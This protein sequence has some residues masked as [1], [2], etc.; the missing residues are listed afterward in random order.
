MITNRLEILLREMECTC[1]PDRICSHCKA[2]SAFT[3]V[4]N[5]IEAALDLA[6]NDCN[7]DCSCDRYDDEPDAG[8]SVNCDHCDHCAISSILRG[9]S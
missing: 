6:E 3:D 8:H 7:C 9:D 5:A 2:L 4:R 1:Q